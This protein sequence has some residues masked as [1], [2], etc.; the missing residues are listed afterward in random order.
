[1]KN[2]ITTIQLRENVKQELEN[3]KTKKN[4]SYEDVIVRLIDDS[5]IK[6]DKI[7]KLLIE[8]CKE[9]YDFDLKVV[10]EWENTDKEMNKYIEW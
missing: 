4:D 8:Q 3:L 5:S 9:M 10:K 7:K 6:K 2:Q 1:M